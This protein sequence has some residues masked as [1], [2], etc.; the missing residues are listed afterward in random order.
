MNGKAYVV[1]VAVASDGS[2]WIFSSSI[3]NKP[4]RGKS[5]WVRTN[6]AIDSMTRLPYGAIERI[7]GRKIS[8]SDDAVEIDP[9]S[10]LK[11]RKEK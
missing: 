9:F 11:E 6:P 2:E 1:H 5:F 7:I 8:W 4:V 3:A 10:T